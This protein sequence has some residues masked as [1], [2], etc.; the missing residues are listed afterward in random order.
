MAEQVPVTVRAPIVAGQLGAVTEVL[1]NKS[2]DG[3]A[4]DLRLADLPGVHFART[5]VLES[6]TL[7]SG[8][9]VPASLVYMADV[10]GSVNRHLRDLVE[11]APTGVDKLFGNCL[12][13]P[14]K[15]DDA[16]RIAWLRSHTVAAAAYYVHTVGRTVDRI[17]DETRLYRCLQD[18][19]DRRE[20]AL[21]PAMTPAQLRDQLRDAVLRYAD[22]P[23]IV[24]VPRG[25][26][27]L[28]NVRDSV[29]LLGVLAVLLAAAPVLIPVAIVWLL[30][31]WTLKGGLEGR[32]MS[33]P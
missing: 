19:L 1:S 28:R 18:I 4:R 2:A 11:S 7:Q 6:A 9:T 20:I 29:Q 31:I 14:G 10:D 15:P 24:D 27:L 23:W 16:Q 12:G 22:F 13:Y 8:E 26:G 33:S 17:K 30:L 21:T 3:P 32:W 25:A 5:F